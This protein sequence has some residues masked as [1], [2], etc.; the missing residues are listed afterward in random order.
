VL[1]FS[2]YI[3]SIAIKIKNNEVPG[4]EKK[5]LPC[6]KTRMLPVFISLMILLM[7]VSPA[8]AASPVITLLG[9]DP[10]SLPVDSVGYFDAGATASDPEDG[11]LT[12]SIVVSDNVRVS[13]VGRYS[14]RY[15]VTDAD[16][17]MT[18]A[19]RTV[20]VVSRL[21]PATIPKFRTPLVIPPEM[22]KTNTSPS[23][24]YYEIAVREFSQQILP[25]G[26]PRTTVWGY[27]SA[28]T[29]GTYNYPA[30][31]IEAT[32]N[33]LTK[34]RWINGLV[35]QNGNYLPH[36]LPVDQTLHWANPPGGL[37]GRDRHGR[38]PEPYMGPVP[39]ITHVHGA[40]TNQESDGY[41][42]A[43]Y[44][45]AA[46]NIPAGHAT[47][48]TYYD[49][50]RN[51][52]PVGAE[53][54]PGSAVFEYPNDQR[55]ATL[56]Y[57]DHSLG[58]TR[59]NVYAG[60][61]GF[62]LIRN[63][64]D[65]LNLGYNRPGLTQG[66]GVDPA[67]VITE[68]PV[69]IQDRS[70][71]SDGSLFYPDSRAFFDGFAGPYAPES[72]IAPTWNP[73]F[74]GDS[75]VVNGK[76]WPY[77]DVQ[78]RQY[79][80]RI[81]NG[82]QARFLILK[83]DNGMA[84]TQIGTEGGFLP[85]PVKLTQLLVG[86]A[87]RADVILDFTKIPAGTNITMQNTGPDEPY[88]GGVPC[89]AGQ[90]PEH[91]PGCDFAPANPATTG[92]VMQFR[93]IPATDPDSSI[94]AGSIVL[95]AIADPGPADN[96]RQ[97]SLNELD[98]AVLTHDHEAIGPQAAMLGTV[99][100][101]HTG[102]VKGM[103]MMWMDA[104]TENIN[105]GDTEEWEIYDFTMDAHPIHLHQVQFRVINREI[106]DPMAGTPGTV[107]PPESWESGY[108]DTVT[109]YPG[110]LTRIRARFDLPGQFVWHCHIL[111]HEDNEM[112]RPYRVLGN[113]SAAGNGMATGFPGGKAVG[114]KNTGRQGIDG[115]VEGINDFI[116][117]I[118][119]NH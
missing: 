2:T 27:G 103:P 64:P 63:G 53:W 28:T 67:D 90:D 79:R 37:Y 19:T 68:I 87:E 36:L 96:V 80:L 71:N 50:F 55:A 24:D 58:M 102:N 83:M 92:Q 89:P 106:F 84:F 88:G 7:V 73:E 82:D 75:I 57:H 23:M 91:T 30:F 85:Q 32:W 48:G 93:V 22:P 118:F 46:N 94:P 97:V 69:A 14:V 49:I 72:D 9:R 31:T 105:L 40:H 115:W 6:R 111:E 35:D 10:V 1:A 17:N 52:S 15:T 20:N 43:W 3:V 74:F 33:K 117:T 76:T 16:R 60:P 18:T 12:G 4:M 99:M 78:Q 56:W 34:V 51:S 29:P 107:I 114:V 61:T 11:D 25:E 101:D 8:S 42:E 110:Q 81:L 13:T 77:L 66:S 54:I 38:N 109:V 26:M 70:F 41:P 86:P 108:K 113:G 119:R 5:Q 65:D 45:P 59:T 100:T 98:S 47:T 44:L 116:S 21:D 95:P 39:A 104:V 62:Y 112:M